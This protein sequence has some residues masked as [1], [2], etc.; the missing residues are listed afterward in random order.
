MKLATL[1]LF[2]VALHAQ[3]ENLLPNA[4][5]EES[6][7]PAQW[8]DLNVWG[9]PGSFAVDD[10]IAHTGAHSFRISATQSTQSWLYGPPIPVAPGEELEASAWVRFKDLRK[11]GKPGEGNPSGITL[12]ANFFNDDAPTKHFEDSASTGGE[13]KENE[14]HDLRGKVKVPPL[15]ATIRLRI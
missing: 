4:G 5:M 1:M 14:W 10:K 8:K 12:V 9:A 13:A 15:A 11:K 6:H 2:I 3:A 7:L